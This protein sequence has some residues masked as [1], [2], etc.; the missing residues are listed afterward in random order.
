MRYGYLSDWVSSSK[1]MF[2]SSKKMFSKQ[3][4]RELGSVKVTEVAVKEIPDLTAKFIIESDVVPY[5]NY[6]YVEELNV[7]IDGLSIT[8]TA[9][10][11]A[12]SNQYCELVSPVDKSLKPIVDGSIYTY[13]LY[14]NFKE[15][16]QIEGGYY[17]GVEMVIPFTADEDNYL[18]FNGSGFVGITVQLDLDGDFLGEDFNWEYPENPYFYGLTTTLF[19]QPDSSPEEFVR[20]SDYPNYGIL[21]FPPDTVLCLSVE[22]NT[23]TKE[24]VTKLVGDNNGSTSVL[25][26]TL[27][28]H[29]MS[30][31]EVLSPQPAFVDFFHG[32]YELFNVT[33]G[34]NKTVFEVYTNPP[35]TF[36]GYP[37]S[38]FGSIVVFN[39]DVVNIRN[40]MVKLKATFT[41][42]DGNVYPTGSYVVV[43]E[44]GEVKGTIKTRKQILDLIGE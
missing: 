5:S 28:V 3:W 13:N 2:M 23:T 34:V 16:L 4:F 42:M 40:R 33:A 14:F 29:V 30:L 7:S 26:E 44:E 39:K 43:N 19:N 25:R 35:Q 11:T 24:V 36:T 6:V 38:N 27:L 20:A 1:E 32:D 22:V 18:V 12:L 21:Q 8:T 9:T 37:A 15:W 41:D 10:E 31:P 17:G